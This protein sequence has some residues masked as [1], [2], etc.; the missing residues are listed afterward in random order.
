MRKLTRFIAAH[1]HNAHKRHAIRVSFNESNLIFELRGEF[2]F[3]RQN[4]TRK[5]KRSQTER[6]TFV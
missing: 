5:H 4:L 2:V 3:T 6:L 1:K